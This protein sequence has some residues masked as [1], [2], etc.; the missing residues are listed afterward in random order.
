ML[1]TNMLAR[2]A[3]ETCRYTGVLSCREGAGGVWF[4]NIQGR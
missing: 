4:Q 3:L 1:G 2:N